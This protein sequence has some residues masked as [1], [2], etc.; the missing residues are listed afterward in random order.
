MKLSRFDIPYNILKLTDIGAQLYRLKYKKE[1]S[2][3]EHTSLLIQHASVL[4]GYAEAWIKSV[5]KD[6][7]AI[8]GVKVYV[9]A[10]VLASRAN[11]KISAPSIKEP[12]PKEDNR[13]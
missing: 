4:Y 11:M 5:G 9:N 2:A 13:E 6:R 12:N 1:L 3:Q 7:L 8:S 10:T